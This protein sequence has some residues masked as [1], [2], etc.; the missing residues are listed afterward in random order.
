MAVKKHTE[1]DAIAISDPHF[2]IDLAGYDRG[3]ELLEVWNAVLDYAGSQK[4]RDVL[5]AGDIF[6]RNKP[7]PNATADFIKSVVRREWLRLQAIG[8]NHDAH[9]RLKSSAL[10]PL[11]AFDLDRF[12]FHTQPCLSNIAGSVP[13]LFLPYPVSPDYDDKI[14]IVKSNW[15][16]PYFAMGHFNIPNAEVGDGLY[17]SNPGGAVIPNFLDKK[18]SIIIN[19][20]YH[21]GQELKFGKATVLIPGSLIRLNFGDT[22]KKEFIQ[23][24]FIFKGEALTDIEYERVETPKV[25]RLIALKVD[26]R[27]GNKIKL[28]SAKTFKNSIVRVDCV[29]DTTSDMADFY[30]IQDKVRK[31]ADHIMPST[32]KVVSA[33]VADDNAK[34]KADLKPAEALEQFAKDAPLDDVFRKAVIKKG[35]GIL[36]R[37]AQ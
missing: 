19:G 33:R 34:I 26:L 28:P 23:L 10:A 35:T 7:T 14:K 30:E 1:K 6:H 36:E 15:K 31:H 17:L 8:G 27:K 12:S 32:P 29:M 22:T 13:C 4:I 16:S 11:D 24:R 2:D 25:K 20:H 18:G 3:P 5:I 37:V 9:I 21:F